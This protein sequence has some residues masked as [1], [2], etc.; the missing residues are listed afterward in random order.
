[1]FTTQ[2]NGDFA[3]TNARRNIW[4]TIDCEVTI[5]ETSEVIEFTASPDDSEDYGRTLYEQLDTTYSSQVALCPEQERNDAF[6]AMARGERNSLLTGCDWTQ[7]PDVPQS[8]RE[9]WASYRQALRDVPT[10]TGFP[11]EITWPTPPA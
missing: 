3:F 11:Y 8:T 9:L 5:E 10:Q 7:S 2:E 4:G 1:M 6:A